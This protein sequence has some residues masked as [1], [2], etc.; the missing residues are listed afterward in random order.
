VNPGRVLWVVGAY[1]AG[2]FPSAYIVI[3]A[4]R[5]QAVLEASNRRSG[6]GDAHVLIKAHLGGAWAALA[7]ILD[8]AKGLVY[9]LAAEHLGNL[10]ETWLAVVGALIVVGHSFPLYARA[11]GGRGLSA[12]AGVLL[13]LLPVAMVVAGILIVLGYVLR[14]TG[15]ASTLGFGAAPLVAW[16]QGQPGPRVAMAA[17]I[18]GVIL[19]RRAEGLQLS[20]ADRGWPRALIRRLLFDADRPTGLPV[21]GTEEAS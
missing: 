18:F 19:L 12:A 8:V 13:A 17:A 5:A 4:K 3:R 20:A 2:T 10:S 1:L 15:P 7:A 16:I 11:L 14:N 6:E 9:A 21:P